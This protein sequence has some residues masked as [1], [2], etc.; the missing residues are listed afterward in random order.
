VTA[1]RLVACGDPQASFDALQGVLSRAGVLAGP[2]LSSSTPRVADDVRLLSIGDHFDWGPPEDRARVAASGERTLAWLADHDEDHVVVL[3]GNHDL[4]RVG[5]LAGF[6]D[7][8]HFAAVQRLADAHYHAAAP[9]EA[10]QSAEAAF[11]RACPWL[12]GTE[13]VARDLSSFRVSQRRLVTDLLRARRLRLAHAAHGL[14]FTHAGVTRAALH[15]L[16]L[17]DDADAATV[18]RALNAA[19]DAAVDECLGGPTPRPLVIPGLHR[20][21]DGV[22]EGDGVL[23]HRP[24]HR[25]DGAWLPPRRYDPRTL[26]RGLW[27]VTGHVGDKRCIASLGPWVV[28]GAHR[29]GVVRH[30]IAHDGRVTYDHGL[31]PPRAA[32]PDDAA[33][34]VFIDGALHATTSGTTS[35]TT[36]STDEAHGR[37][38]P[39]ELFDATNGVVRPG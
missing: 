37:P 22:G 39:Y 32:L 17:P 24:I 3:A 20:P 28:P 14:L 15:R 33:V 7:D 5:E 1:R 21:G 18:A 13:V 6:V 4:A 23:Y 34:V 30:L 16:G 2:S 38:L 26:P 29:H 19:L 35:A 9:D 8:D 12:P 31:P 36:S 25:D 27:Q 10:A 11:R